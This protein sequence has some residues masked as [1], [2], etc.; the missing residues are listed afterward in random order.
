MMTVPNGQIAALRAYLVGG[1]DEWQHLHWQLV[2]DGAAD[3]YGDL[4]YTAFITAV[5]R[6]FAPT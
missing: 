5:R 6:R 3:G 2:E 4:V 1:A